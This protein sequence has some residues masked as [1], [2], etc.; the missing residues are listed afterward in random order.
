VYA[1]QPARQTSVRKSPSLKSA[2]RSFRKRASVMTSTT[3]TADTAAPSHPSIDSRSP[4]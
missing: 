2:G 1:L 4:R 3:P